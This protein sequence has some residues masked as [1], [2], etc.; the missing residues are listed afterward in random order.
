M[1]IFQFRLDVLLYR[2]VRVYILHMFDSILFT[3][4]NGAHVPLV[5]A[6]IAEGFP[7]QPPYSW[8][9]GVLACLY[10]HMC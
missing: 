10:R 1:S 3:N 2:Y 6:T 4:L 9:L 8:D 7:V 5:L